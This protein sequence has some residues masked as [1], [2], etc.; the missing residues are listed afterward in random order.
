[1]DSGP[2]H[3]SAWQTLAQ[4]HGISIAEADFR[5][6]FGQR[7]YEILQSLFGSDLTT[8][9]LERLSERKEALFR[10]LVAGRHITPLPGAV[11]LV[12][13]LAEAGCPQALC[14]STSRQNIEL[15]LGTLG[16]LTLFQAIVSAE[17]V[18]RGKPDPQG[19]LLAARRL[20]IEPRATL[21][22]EDSLPGISAAKAAGMYCLAVATTHPHERLTI[23]DAVVDSLE[24]VTARQLLGP[25]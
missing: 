20:A 9:D 23:A 14:S 11:P 22:V 24:G 19:F 13:A 25:S 18:E 7:N 5:A 2:Y 21:V 17:D 12:H 4:E 15:V 6:T 1:V 8:D 3:L 16:L 10:R